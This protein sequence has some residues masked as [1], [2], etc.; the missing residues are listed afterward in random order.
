[1]QI[2]FRFFIYVEILALRKADKS[3]KMNGAS[4]LKMHQV[5]TSVTKKCIKV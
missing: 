1:M 5:Q 2:L 3:E 4:P